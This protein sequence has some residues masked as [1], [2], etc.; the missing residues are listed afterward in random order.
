M[1]IEMKKITKL[2][3]LF[4]LMVL[5]LSLCACVEAPYIGENGNWFVDGKDTGI[6]AKGEAG[7]LGPDATGFTVSSVEVQ[8]VSQDGLTTTYKVTLSTGTEF[9]FDKIDGAAVEIESCEEVTSES[10]ELGKVF[11]ITFKDGYKAK[12][13][14][15]N[16]KDGKDGTLTLEDINALE[17][18][19]NLEII[20]N[21]VLAPKTLTVNAEALASG[22]SLEINSGSILNDKAILLYFDADEIGEGRILL[23]EGS[24]EGSSYLEITK[25]Y[26][27]FYT[28]V[29]GEPVETKKFTHNLPYSNG[30]YI[31]IEVTAGRATFRAKSTDKSS[32]DRA[33]T[34]SGIGGGLYVKAEDTAMTKVQL[35]YFADSLKNDVY[36]VGDFG[37]AVHEEGWTKCYFDNGYDRALV[38]GYS[39]MTAAEAIVEFERLLTLG[40]PRYAVWCVGMNDADGESTPNASWLEATER[41]LALCTEK[42][43]IPVLVTLPEISDTNNAE[44]NDW[45]KD[46]AD[47]YVKFSYA[48]GS[49]NEDVMYSEGNLTELGAQ[50]LYMQ[51]L[52][53]FPELLLK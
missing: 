38:S 18:V 12:F 48:I 25:S 43:I 52:V 27:K 35:K 13:F 19:A 29:D 15:K 10:T 46:N 53:D 40:T 39:E 21:T 44:K 31:S 24:G 51:I 32:Y 37:I 34:W 16:G 28:V 30:I 45:V 1:E 17:G 42:E 7:E 8:S 2:F 22:E 3:L 5:T 14:V 23:G 36:V 49:D 47:K 9:T 26:F 11:E 20:A 33:I 4:A 50:S 41:F 6:Y